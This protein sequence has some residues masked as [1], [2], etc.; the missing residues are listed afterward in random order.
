MNGLLLRLL[1]HV[2]PKQRRYLRDASL[3]VTR[4]ADGWVVWGSLT[5]LSGVVY[6]VDIKSLDPRDVSYSLIKVVENLK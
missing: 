3:R 2:V 4:Q 1:V 5:S 6:A